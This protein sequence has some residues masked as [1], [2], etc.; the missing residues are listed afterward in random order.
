MKTKS[1]VFLFFSIGSINAMDMDRELVAAALV[2]LSQ[3]SSESGSVRMVWV[4]SPDRQTMYSVPEYLCDVIGCR[5]STYQR[6]E[7]AQHKIN[8]HTQK[9]FKCDKCLFSTGL[10]YYWR[11]HLGV[12]KQ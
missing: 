6:S 5:F 3:S 2:A 7:L 11:K 12:H 1:L 4:F 8:I 10:E 9:V